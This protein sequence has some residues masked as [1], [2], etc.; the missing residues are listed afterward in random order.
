MEVFCLLAS[1]PA[2]GDDGA[3]AVLFVCRQVAAWTFERD[4]SEDKRAAV[5]RRRSTALQERNELANLHNKKIHRKAC[6]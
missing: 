2:V 3:G 4:T 5:I 6:P 1:F